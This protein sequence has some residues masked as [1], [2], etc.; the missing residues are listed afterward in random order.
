MAEKELDVNASFDSL[1][2]AG[3]SLD[4]MKETYPHGSV[5]MDGPHQPAMTPTETVVTPASSKPSPHYDDPKWNQ[6]VG[7]PNAW[8]GDYPHGD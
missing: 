1:V 2:S 5:P 7:S 3:A 6:T 4:V 8:P